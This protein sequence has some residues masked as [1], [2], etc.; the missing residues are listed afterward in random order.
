MEQWIFYLLIAVLGIAS[1]AYKEW[2]KNQQKKNSNAP[3]GQKTARQRAEELLQEAREMAQRNQEQGQ[4][5]QPKAPEGSLETLWSMEYEGFEQST[6]GQ[7]IQPAKVQPIPE[8]SLKTEES[9]INFNAD[10]ARKA[11]IYQA[12]M[13]RPYA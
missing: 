5:A 8:N 3:K 9:A 7:T 10:E 13:E 11:I 2:N 4:K 6:P 12:I 1:S